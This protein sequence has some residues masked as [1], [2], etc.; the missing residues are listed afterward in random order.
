M[1]L[2]PVKA[3]ILQRISQ[4]KTKTLTVGCTPKTDANLS[5]VSIQM[6]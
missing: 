4:M 5:L 2:L 1:H 3:T 6:L